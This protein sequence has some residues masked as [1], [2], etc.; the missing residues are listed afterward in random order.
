VGRRRP[1]I[2]NENPASSYGQW[3]SLPCSLSIL[4]VS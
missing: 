2:G 3:T 4:F 1:I